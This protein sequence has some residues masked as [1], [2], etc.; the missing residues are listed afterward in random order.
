M[1]R[2]S[3]LKLPQVSKMLK[4]YRQLFG[5]LIYKWEQP[6]RLIIYA[7]SA[8]NLCLADPI[9]SLQVFHYRA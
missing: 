9:I 6:Y 4:V 7:G 2:S 3:A 5:F 1:R 8:S